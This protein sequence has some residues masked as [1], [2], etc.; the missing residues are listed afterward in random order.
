[1]KHRNI[2]IAA[3]A[4]LALVSCKK[5]S[6]LDVNTNPNSL[7]SSTPDFTFAA[8]ANRIAATLGPNETGEYWSGQWTQSSTYIISS[9]LFAYQFNNTNFNYYDGMYDILEDLQYS[10]SGAT[11]TG[12]YF[13]GAARVL[14]AYV[15]QELVD[16]YGNVPYTDALKGTASLAPK[17]DDQ[18]FIYEDLIKVLDTAITVLRANPLSAPLAGSDIIFGSSPATAATRWIQ[19][20]NSLKMRIL[21][22]Q[23]RIAGR[24]AYIIA[25]VNKAAAT[26]EGFLPTG[27]DV[28][29]NPGY[30]ASTGKQNPFY[31]NWG[32]NAAGTVQAIARYPRPTTFLLNSLIA[33]KDTFRLKRL[34]YPKG[35]Q[36]VNPEIVSNYVGVPFGAA[37]GYLSQN[38]SYI[39]PSQ[40]VKGEFARPMVL[41]TN[42]EL[43]FNLAEAKQRYGAA[44]TLPNTAQAYYEQGV[45]ESFRITGTTTV[46]GAAA[47]TTLLTSGIDLADWT[48]SPDKLK[49]IWMQKWIALTNYSGLEA[50]SEFR[51]TNFPVTPPSASTS[52]TQALPKR[53]FYPQSE[54]ASNGANVL[55]QGTID[56][57]TTKIFWDVD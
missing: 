44:V 43:Q 3:C 29:S 17:F 9:T 47:A 36:G 39:G 45:K 16:L 28:T 12:A 26:A 53:L 49:A 52:P 55:A 57:F 11:G 8:A 7:P 24:D 42:A 48:A 2:I 5:T 27:V 54:L 4:S 19:F 25:E 22:R 15:F 41:M 21:I 51:R 30:V 32:Y 23:S 20:A 38:T 50:W 6:W 31:E 33:T 46:Y 40:L 37:S 1:M 13:G 34:F 56:V 35:G 10:I 14:K 18:K